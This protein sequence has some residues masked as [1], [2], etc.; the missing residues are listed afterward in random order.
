MKQNIEQVIKWLIYATFFIPLL[1]LPSSYIF[2]FIVPKIV[3]LR[4]LIEV[5]IFA[6]ITLLVINWQE[7]KP[8]FSYINIAIFLFL[9]S[10]AI[11]T[12]VGTDAYHSFWDNHE[13]M[14]GLF[15]LL[16]YVFFYYIAQVVFKD[17]KDWKWAGRVFLLGGFLVMFIGW[18]QTQNPDLLLNQGATRV[19]STLGNSIYVGNYGLFLTCLASLLFIREKNNL[20]KWFYVIAGLFGFMGMF[21]SGTRGSMLGLIA[22]VA[23]ALIVYIVVLKNHPKIRFSLLSLAILG[24]VGISLLYNFRQTDFVKN[25]PAIGRTINTSLADVEGSPRWIAWQIGLQSWKEKP[26]FGWGP[27]NYFYAFNEHYQSKSLEFGY[28]ETW[29]DN[30]HNILV[31]TLAVQ[32]AFGL[33]TYLVLYGVIIV[34]LIIAC[35]A[36]KIDSHFM[37]IGGAFVVAHFVSV[38]T[39]FEDPTSYIY[40]MF[41]FGMVNSMSLR[42]ESPLREDKLRVA[43][44]IPVKTGIKKVAQNIQDK[45]IGTGAL[46][47]MVIVCFIIIFIFNIQPSRAN[48]KT[49]DAIRTLSQDPVVGIGITK[50]VLAFTSPHIDD[51]RSDISRTINSALSGSWQKIGKDKSN[52][53]LSLVTE[54]LE[55]NLILHPLDVRNQLTLAQMYQ[56]QAMINNNGTYLIKSENVL[57]DALSKSPK[58][59]Q[60]IYGLAGVKIQ[61][62]KNQEAVK[63]VEQALTDDSKIPETYW[64]LAYAYKYANQNDKVKEIIDLAKKNNIHFSDQEQSMVNQLVPTPTVNNLKKK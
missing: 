3:Y 28:G 11:S 62:G 57:T 49:L 30:A 59:Q 64:R 41:W 26:I 42:A 39:V 14:L 19:A 53:L 5:M 16:H 7:Y 46:A 47:S 43:N 2:P 27:N 22:G 23:F 44:V 32:G 34:V 31:N 9:L 45:K 25:L 36:K 24:V 18:L 13:R 6:Y 21:W 37:T 4:S 60:I 17:W 63:L 12:F 8:K 48:Q 51:I 15:T 1:V 33:F 54:N 58:R 35:R 55:K 29:F 52:E 20:W 40:L 50:E 38:I 61:L 10:F 56:Q